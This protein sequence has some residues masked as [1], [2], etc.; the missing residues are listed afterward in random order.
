VGAELLVG[1]SAQHHDDHVAHESRSGSGLFRRVAKGL[2][3]RTGSA[4]AAVLVVCGAVAWL[5][6]GV[7]SGFPRWWE[8]L[9]TGGV[10]LLTFL[11]VVLL[12][13]TQNHDALAIQ[14][15]LDELIRAT[16]GATNRMMTVEEASP[17][18]L[19]RIQ[20]DFRSQSESAAR[21]SPSG[22]QVP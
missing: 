18:D 20:A 22:L 6:L 13:H 19:E 15:K 1:V 5:A 4:T 8:L 12:Q 3:A 16:H 9:V 21:D 17:E 11:V 2:S 10:P 7:I 14:L